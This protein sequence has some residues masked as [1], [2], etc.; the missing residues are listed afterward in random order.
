MKRPKA[1]QLQLCFAPD[2]PVGS[3]VADIFEYERHKRIKEIGIII[4]P[5]PI[6]HYWQRRKFFKRDREDP[7]LVF[8]ATLSV[9]RWV[10]WKVH[11]RDQLVIIGDEHK[12]KLAITDLAQWE[13]AWAEAARKLR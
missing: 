11:R 13:I 9:G 6:E 7:N 8:V 3:H 5:R 1:E 10:G 4:P 12:C 2:F